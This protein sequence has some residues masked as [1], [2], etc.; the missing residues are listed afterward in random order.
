MPLLARRKVRMISTVPGWMFSVWASFAV[1]AVLTLSIGLPV[2]F[3]RCGRGS[4][5]GYSVNCAASIALPVGFGSFTLVAVPVISGYR[6]HQKRTMN[7]WLESYG[8]AKGTVAEAG[9]TAR[10][11][12]PR[13]LV[14]PKRVLWNESRD[15][16]AQE[17]R[18]DV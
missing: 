16:A 17:T 14:W 7:E 2:I 11:S 3:A 4:L 12:L 9:R 18:E 1:A 5:G 8:I 6:W 15:K 13:I 10:G